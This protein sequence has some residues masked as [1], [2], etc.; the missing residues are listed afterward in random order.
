MYLELACGSVSS[1]LCISSILSKFLMFPEID[2]L[3]LLSL[4]S[5]FALEEIL[6]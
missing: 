4:C 2:G 5:I 3:A 6:L 1:A